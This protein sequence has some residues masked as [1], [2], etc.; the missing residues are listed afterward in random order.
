MEERRYAPRVPSSSIVRVW[1]GS[2]EIRGQAVDVSAQGIA[3]ETSSEVR[4]ERFVRL[5]MALESGSPP[6]DFDAIVVRRERRGKMMRWGLKVHEAPTHVLSQIVEFVRNGLE[7]PETA[8]ADPLPL[9][10]RES[11][12]GECTTVKALYEKALSEIQA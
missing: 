6:V 4:L 2:Q 1:T 10:N 11:A 12:R 8:P 3:V 5:C 7:P 9:P